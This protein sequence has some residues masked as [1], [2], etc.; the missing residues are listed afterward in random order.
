M[1]GL[2]YIY[3]SAHTILKP[4][5]AFIYFILVNFMIEVGENNVVSD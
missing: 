5:F 4:T 3:N 2:L 1:Q